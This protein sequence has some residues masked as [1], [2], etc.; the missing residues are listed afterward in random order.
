M[1]CGQERESRVSRGVGREQERE[2]SEQGS[3][4]WAGERYR[5]WWRGGRP[6]AMVKA[7]LV[8]VEAGRPY[9]TVQPS[10]VAVRLFDEG[11]DPHVVALVAV[12][13][14][15]DLV[16]RETARWGALR[17]QR[18]E[19]TDTRRDEVVFKRHARFGNNPLQRWDRY[20]RRRYA[21]RVHCTA[22]LET[23]DSDLLGR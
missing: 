15:E 10:D 17:T 5:L 18:Q 3:G 12:L 21:M 8:K 9:V 6:G 13:L 11:H 16:G 23:T 4:T 22:Q 2:Q 1:G 14:R 19:G 7:N 20:E